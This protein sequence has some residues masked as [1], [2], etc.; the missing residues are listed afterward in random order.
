MIS[1]SWQNIQTFVGSIFSIIFSQVYIQFHILQIFRIS[2]PPPP[3]KK[4][5][6]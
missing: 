1:E 3:Q 6:S 2:P 4:N 5:E